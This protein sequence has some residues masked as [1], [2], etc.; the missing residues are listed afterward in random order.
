MMI[1]RKVDIQCAN[2]WETIGKTTVMQFDLNPS[3]LRKEDNYADS[4]FLML[5][6]SRR[7]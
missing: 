4:H 3:V 2:Y 5:S 7:A 1:A 6:I